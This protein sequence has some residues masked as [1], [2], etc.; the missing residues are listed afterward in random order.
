M[1]NASRCHTLCLV[2]EHPSSLIFLDAWTCTAPPAADSRWSRGP[3]GPAVHVPHQMRRR[4]PPRLHCL[5]TDARGI[6]GASAGGT[7]TDRRSHS[8]QR[9]L[10]RAG[11]FRA[12]P[13][14][15]G[16]SRGPLLGT[17]LLSPPPPPL[18]PRGLR[19][20]NPPRERGEQGG[21]DRQWVSS[22]AAQR[23]P[24]SSVVVVVWEV[25]TCAHGTAMGRHP[26]SPGP[27]DAL[28]GEAGT[29]PPPP[30]GRPAYAQPLSPWRQVPASMAFV[31][32]SNRP[33]PPD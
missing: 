31:T 20:H 9:P 13:G 22:R 1:P 14:P 15:F 19:R 27:T 3:L 10:R 29:P 26:A 7:P 28:E 21:Q 30:P 16:R 18:T 17:V 2:R 12:R 6:A 8:D 4:A 11:P 23:W 24:V 5:G 25:R 32:D 33:Q